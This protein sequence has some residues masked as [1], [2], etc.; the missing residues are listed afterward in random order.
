VENAL[1]RISHDIE[2]VH[3]VA[4]PDERYGEEAGAVISWKDGIN[5]D[6]AKR[7]LK[8]A[9]LL[10]SPYIS[11]YETPKY[12]A[13]LPVSELPMTSTGKV[14]RSVLKSQLP[15]EKFESIYGLSKTSEYR[16]TVL[17][18]YSRWS[19]PSYELHKKCWGI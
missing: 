9:L 16:F 3:V 19:A 2:Q 13:S 11:A 18:R 17:H 4:V 12:I 14:Q 10:G 1:Q 6:A 15:Y 7:K 5:V 8:T